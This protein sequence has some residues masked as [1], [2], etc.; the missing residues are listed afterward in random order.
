[1]KNSPCYPRPSNKSNLRYKLNR[2]V[3]AFDH[4]ENR[5]VSAKDQGENSSSSLGNCKQSFINVRAAILAHVRS[6]TILSRR[7]RGPVSAFTSL[8]PFTCVAL[9][10]GSCSKAERT[11][12]NKITSETSEI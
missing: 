6:G 3:F 8:H 7:E 12:V 9:R 1:M 2:Q 11:D 10:K 4:L 5:T